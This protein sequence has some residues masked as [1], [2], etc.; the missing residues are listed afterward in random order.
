MLVGGTVTAAA[1]AGRRLPTSASRVTATAAATWVVLGGTSLRRAG[2]DLATDL[3]A[4]D[5]PNGDLAAAR[6]RLPTLCGRDPAGLDVTGIARGGIES[7]AENTADAVVAPLLWG[8]LAG[9][10]GLVGYRAVNTLDAMIGYRNDRYREFGWAAAR[11]DDIATLL[12][13]RVAAA[14]TWLCAPVVGG[15]PF[16]TFWVT[17]RDGRSHPSPNAGQVEAA[18]AGALSLRLGG[19]LPYPHGVEYRPHLG[20]G[21]PPQPHDLD[22]AATL[23]G[24]VSAVSLGVAV[25]VALARPAAVR[26]A[27]RVAVRAAGRLAR[28]FG[29]AQRAERAERVWPASRRVITSP[30]RLRP[31]SLGGATSLGPIWPDLRGGAGRDPL[32]WRQTPG[33]AAQLLDRQ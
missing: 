13:A 27:R 3:R 11:L 15:A 21:R 17:R 6:A 25:A 31:A 10:P 24:A 33:V 12:P 1:V 4:A 26:A 32:P 14:A 23:S 18:F 20:F 22:R 29:Q 30:D 7:L 16:D 2:R 9:L 19:E 5:A 8:A 28:R